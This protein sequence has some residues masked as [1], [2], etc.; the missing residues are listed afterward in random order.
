MSLDQ[1]WGLLALALLPAATALWWRIGR[2]PARYPV[3]FTNV[4]VLASVSGS[5]RRWRQLVPPLLML[6][7]L[8]SASVAVARPYA[9]VAVPR[10]ATL[11][12]VFDVSGSMSATDIEPT[13]L[14]AAQAAAQK[15]V[16]R[17]PRALRV[18]VIAFSTEPH[19]VAPP[20]SDHRLIQEAIATLTPGGSTAIGDAL[21]AALRV[22]ERAVAE[23]SSVATGSAPAVARGLSIVLL[24]DG[25]QNSGRL[26][27]LQAASLAQRAGVPV[28]TVALGSRSGA[29]LSEFGALR[30]E[31]PDVSTLHAIA[32]ATGG[33]FTDATNATVLNAA[34]V[35]LGR[36]IGWTIAS[37]EIGSLFL[38]AAAAFLVAAGIVGTLWSPRLP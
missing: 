27:P 15:L 8:S 17:L 2:R 36:Q 11:M 25:H 5:G 6:V 37:K 20:T 23:P 4:A 21:A 28:Y 32:T 9:R 38:A 3:R 35:R 18:G 1:P 22:G 7:A 29:L 26:Q 24:S 12:L 14:G 34:Y 30:L 10:R 31:P 13:R 16:A 33:R 19:E